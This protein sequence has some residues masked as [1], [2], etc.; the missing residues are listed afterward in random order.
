M[1]G[2]TY[3]D[4]AFAPD[5][6]REDVEIGGDDADTATDSGD[7]AT[8]DSRVDTFVGDT[9]AEIA[10][11]TASDSPSDTS[12]LDA[13]PETLAADAAVDT[14]PTGCLGSTHL[15]CADFDKSVKPEDGF[16][17]M[18][19]SAEGSL[20]LDPSGRSSPNSLLCQTVAFATGI[21]AAN[22]TKT[23]IAPSTDTIIRV[24]AWV[25]LESA[26]FPGKSGS[27]FILKVQRTGDG[28]TLSLDSSGFFA[29]AIGTTYTAYPLTKT[30]PVGVWFKVRMDTRLHPTSGTLTVWIEDMTTPVLEKT[31]ISTATVVTAERTVVL[32]LYSQN[33]TAT[34][35][36]R[37]DDVTAD[38]LP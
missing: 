1:T 36:A 4:I 16:D 38:Y 32:G 24:E 23:F 11:E 7:D 30:V 14:P 35:R 34:F 22:V 19:V 3:P 26:T 17:G 37:Y 25:K 9:R 29:D 8:V 33:G 15:F 18:D 10:P 20:A 21:A 31:A 2:C 13:G 5:A 12:P 28:A 6:A 27:A